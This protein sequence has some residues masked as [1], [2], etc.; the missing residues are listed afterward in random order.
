M[1]GDCKFSM[2][3]NDSVCLG[4]SLENFCKVT[5]ILHGD[6]SELIFLVNPDKE[7]LLRVVEDSSGF[8]P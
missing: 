1:I 3:I 4:E 7:C 8:R 6:D 5:A 2:L